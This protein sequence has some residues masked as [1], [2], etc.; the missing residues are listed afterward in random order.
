[1]NIQYIVIIK[2]YL[3]YTID[4]NGLAKIDSGKDLTLI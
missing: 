4:F 1:M 3:S 2:L